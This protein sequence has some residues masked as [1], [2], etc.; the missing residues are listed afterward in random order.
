[1]KDFLEF[2][3]MTNFALVVLGVGLFLVMATIP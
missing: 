2:R 1:M 3:D